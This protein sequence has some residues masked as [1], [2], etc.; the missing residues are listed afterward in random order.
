MT[1]LIIIATA[2][3]LFIAVLIGFIRWDFSEIKKGSPIRHGNELIVRLPCLL[4]SAVGLSVAAGHWWVIFISYC[5]LLSI[6]WE[7]FDGVLNKKRGFNWRFN[8][9]FND[10]GHKDAFTDKLLKQLEPDQ[11]AFLKWSLIIIFVFVYCWILI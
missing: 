9:S 2:A 1:Q 10:P 5:M 6:W 11:Q 7:F 3:V 8:G 4:P